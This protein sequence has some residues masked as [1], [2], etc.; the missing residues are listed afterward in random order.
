MQRRHTILKV[1]RRKTWIELKI[2]R[3]GQIAYNFIM[4]Q[5]H[6]GLVGKITLARKI[7]YAGLVMVTFTYL[8]YSALA[9]FRYEAGKAAEAPL[10]RLACANAKCANTED[11]KVKNIRQERCSR[12]GSKMG[13][14]LQCQS[15]KK[16]YPWFKPNIP[17][18][19]PEKTRQLM[20]KK[21]MAC[22]FCK[23]TQTIVVPPDPPKQPP[24]GKAAEPEKTKATEPAKTRGK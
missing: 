14:A 5:E 9:A 23:S 2:E 10:C 15:C 13:Y 20:L 24:K 3:L 17:S 4:M 6:R 8:S 12:C 1:P 7:A 16:K 18:D 21:S 19:V 22:V 11:H